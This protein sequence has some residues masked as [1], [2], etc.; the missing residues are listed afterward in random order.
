MTENA[1]PFGAPAANDPFGAPAAAPADPF[2]GGAPPAEQPPAPQPPAAAPVE[3][4]AEEQPPIVNRE[5]EPVETPA[6]DPET[7]VEPQPEPTPEPPAPPAEA[8]QPAAQ[9]AAPEPEPEPEASAAAAPVAE[10]RQPDAAGKK[11]PVRYYK[12]LYQTGSE[13]W[14]EAKLPSPDENHNIVLRTSKKTGSPARWL[15]ARNNEHALRLAFAVLGSPTEG[16]TV[17]PIPEG[18]WKPK[19]IAPETQPERVRLAIS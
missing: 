8:E 17:L 1:D 7:P 3:E 12:V 14:T 5:G 11:S 6:E 10:Q 18:G 19:R 4:A 13:Q 9:E 16:V 2:G 15:A